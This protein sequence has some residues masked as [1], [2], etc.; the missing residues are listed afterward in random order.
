MSELEIVRGIEV[1]TLLGNGPELG[2][3]LAERGGHT[4]GITLPRL[5]VLQ[6]RDWLNTWLSETP[7]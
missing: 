4:N 3:L 1:L 7:P 6:L 5:E 2:V